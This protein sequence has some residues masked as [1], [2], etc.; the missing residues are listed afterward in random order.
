MNI[1]GISY[2]LRYV[3]VLLIVM[4]VWYLISLSVRELKWHMRNS[5]IPSKGFFLMASETLAVTNTEG[6]SLPLHPTT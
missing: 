1:F 5:V 3:L 6:M 4:F 2:L